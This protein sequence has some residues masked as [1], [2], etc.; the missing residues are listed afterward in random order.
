MKCCIAYWNSRSPGCPMP[1]SGVEG[2]VSRDC[3]MEAKPKT[4]YKCNETGHISRECPQNTQNDNTGGGYS[5]GGY[6]GGYGGGGGSNTECYKCGKVGHIARA[7]PEA[8]SGGYGGG[9]GAT[10]V[11][12]LV[13]CRVTAYRDLSATIG[14]ISK[15]CPQ[16]QRRACYNC[17]SE[18]HISRDCPNPGTAA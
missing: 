3:T 5:G 1:Q 8:T 10:P 13:T 17:G 12:A 15:D 18:G 9:S 6:G 11:V 2:H 14:H 4:C 7:C 16:P